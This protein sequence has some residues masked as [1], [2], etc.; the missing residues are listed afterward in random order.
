MD[1]R[2]A[3]EELGLD[4]GDQVTLSADERADPT[5][6]LTQSVTIRPH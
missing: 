3:A 4:V 2:S 6:G 1:Q 5:D